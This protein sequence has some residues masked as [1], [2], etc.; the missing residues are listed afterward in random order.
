MSQPS[1]F[2]EL[3]LYTYYT[4]HLAQPGD[5]GLGYSFFAQGSHV[6]LVSL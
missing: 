2:F 3:A 1:H 4:S 5:D 6:W